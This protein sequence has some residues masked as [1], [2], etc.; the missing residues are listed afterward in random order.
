MSN[1]AIE[2][3][4]GSCLIVFAGLHWRYSLW[5]MMSNRYGTGKTAGKPVLPRMKFQR[6]VGTVGPAAFGALFIWA[7]VHG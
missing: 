3:L 6:V 4:I 1:T 2:A 5:W 7:A